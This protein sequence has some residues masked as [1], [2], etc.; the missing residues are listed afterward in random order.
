MVDIYA[1]EFQEEQPA[2]SD[3]IHNA[4]EIIPLKAEK[5][6]YH[7]NESLTDDS[8]VCLIQF[9]TILILDVCYLL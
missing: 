3:E 5:P 2:I 7:L 6:P 1:D 8:E 4:D 9:V